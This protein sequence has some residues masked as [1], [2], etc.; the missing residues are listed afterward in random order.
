MTRTDL[1]GKL[2]GMWLAFIAVSVIAFG[3]LGWR[4]LWMK[5]FHEAYVAFFRLLEAE[6]KRDIEGD[7]SPELQARIG[8]LNV[9]AWRAITRLRRLK[10]RTHR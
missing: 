4:L 6:S 10:R 3:Y 7:Q 1:P 2:H 5:R 9:R 8:R